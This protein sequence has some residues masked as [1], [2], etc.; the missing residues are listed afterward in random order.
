MSDRQYYERVNDILDQSSNTLPANGPGR[1]RPPW[2]IKRWLWRLL[3]GTA[4]VLCLLYV[5][6][7]AQARLRMARGSAFDSVT[8]D[9]YSAIHEKNNRMEFNYLGSDQQTCLRAL[10][11]HAGYAPCWYARRHKEQQ[12]D[13]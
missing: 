10:F 13:Y 7:F 9:R 5:V 12:I 1:P 6:D 8:I 2:P 11:P 4:A 3:L